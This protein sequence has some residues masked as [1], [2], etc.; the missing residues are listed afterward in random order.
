M[1]EY[2]V[3]EGKE[4]LIEAIYGG[5]WGRTGDGL[6]VNDGGGRVALQQPP[7]KGGRQANGCCHQRLNINNFHNSCVDSMES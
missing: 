3:Q 5:D 6:K 7:E 4:H 1:K 2:S